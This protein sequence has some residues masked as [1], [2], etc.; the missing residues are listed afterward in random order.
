MSEGQEPG[1]GRVV[2]DL[3]M[4]KPEDFSLAIAAGYPAPPAVIQFEA[5]D[6]LKRK[7][8]ERWIKREEPDR[9][10]E[11]KDAYLAVAVPMDYPQSNFLGFFSY[12]RNSEGAAKLAAHGG[13][14]HDTPG[15]IR[16]R[17]W[18]HPADFLVARK[19]AL[20]DRAETNLYRAQEGLDPV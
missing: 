10:D 6:V 2:R 4:M 7:V 18:P 15:I 8:F 17:S 11:L 19:A 9:W 16:V 5:S 14:A 20:L 3:D 1:M 13:P 12:E